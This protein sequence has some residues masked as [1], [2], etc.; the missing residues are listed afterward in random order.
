MDKDVK[1]VPTNPIWLRINNVLLISLAICI[2]L[3]VALSMFVTQFQIKNKQNEAILTLFVSKVN[4]ILVIISVLILILVIIVNVTKLRHPKFDL[5]VTKIAKD[6]LSTETIWYNKEKLF[7][8]YDVNI[9]RKQIQDFVR[10]ITSKSNKY[11]YYLGRIDI[12][13]QVIV[14]TPV[15]KKEIP[16]KCNVDKEHDDKW[17]FIPLGLAE[18]HELRDITPIGWYL[19]NDDKMDRIVNTL[20]STSILIAGGTGSGKSVLEQDII[21]HI[22]RHSD[23]IQAVCCDLKRVEFCGLDKFCGIKKVALDIDSIN[24]ALQQTRD[25]MYNRF[26]FISQQGKHKISEINANVDYYEINGHQFQFD[27]L[28]DCKINGEHKLLTIDKIYE[29]VNNGSDVEINDNDVN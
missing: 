11:T 26:K 2:G 1:V 9:N 3:I 27:E 28:F 25:I 13:Q 15:I 14:I 17:N 7:F 24:E 23:K 21:G 18:N 12:D 8:G 22:T 29:E 19:N 4:G 5:W 10:E 20:P 16:K 6:K